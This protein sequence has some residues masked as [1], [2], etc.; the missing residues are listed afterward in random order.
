MTTCT[1]EGCEE[2]PAFPD[3][4]RCEE[5]RLRWLPKERVEQPEPRWLTWTREH[6]NHK[7]MT[8]A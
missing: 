2:T 6:G 1:F 8:A 4:S 5:H 7:D 3:Q